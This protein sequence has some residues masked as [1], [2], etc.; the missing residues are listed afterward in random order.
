MQRTLGTILVAVL[1]VLA[2]CGGVLGG[3]G[4]SDTV[5]TFTPVPVP[6]DEPTPTPVPQLAPG[7]T[8]Q[9]IENASA[10]VVASKSFYRNRSFTT[11]ANFTVLA[12][13]GTVLARSTGTLHA[14]P[15]GEGFRYVSER[16]GGSALINTST[17]PVRTEA[18]WDGERY[19]LKQTYANGTTTYRRLP[20]DDGQT[21]YGFAI[22]GVPGILESVGTANT[23]VAN[24]FTRNGTMLYR[25]RGIARTEWRGN[26]SFRLLVDS[27]GVIHEYWTVYQI[28]FRGNNSTV[29]RE[30]QFSAVNTTDA[31]ERPSWV[32]EALN[33]TT[34]I[35]ENPSRGYDETANG[36]DTNETASKTTT[37]G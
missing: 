2:G 22:G 19:F 24:R 7:L 4:G 27:R 30:T 15:A 17:E 23:T 9:G 37:G 25:V 28:P 3:G 1:V 35:P 18:W 34:P 32:D 26:V 12:S 6:T 20:I 14:G 31:P 8:G 21:G 13:N 29:V 33:Q 11:R 5:E 10:L 36:T 16:N